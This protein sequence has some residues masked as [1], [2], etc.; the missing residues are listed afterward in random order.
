MKVNLLFIKTINWKN[1][2]KIC[3][4]TSKHP[5]IQGTIEYKHKITESKVIK[6]WWKI[7]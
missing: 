2:V 3:H 1:K 4:E 6:Y 7:I 5:Q